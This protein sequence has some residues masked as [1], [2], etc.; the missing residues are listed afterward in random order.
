[1]IS[2]NL[3]GIAPAVILLVALSPH[4]PR[5]RQE[6]SC[7]YRRDR[8]GLEQGEEASRSNAVASRNLITGKYRLTGDRFGEILSLDGHIAQ[9]EQQ[10]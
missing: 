4:R 8:T 7:S 10:P 1:M 3:A 9:E 5:H 6:T 2:R